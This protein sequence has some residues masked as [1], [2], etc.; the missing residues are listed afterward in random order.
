MRTIED[1]WPWELLEHIS[2][3]PEGERLERMRAALLALLIEEEIQWR[4]D[5][6]HQNV[7]YHTASSCA[8]HGEGR[9]DCTGLVDHVG[10]AAERYR[11]QSRWRS[12]AKALLA[13]LPERQ[14]MA[15]LITGYVL[16]PQGGNPSP[17]MMTLAQAC[18]RQIL[19]LQLLGWP[20]GVGWVFDT[21]KALRRTG[22]R[23]REKLL[24]FAGCA[25]NY[26]PIRQGHC[27]QAQ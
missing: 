15:V 8:G 3:E 22:E 1:M 4:V 26:R 19:L 5:L 9:G 24:P 16:T 17:R 21:P 14:L 11:Y 23:G 13:H 2:R 27:Y 25:M 6:R 18:E 12:M 20:P 7:G 10:K